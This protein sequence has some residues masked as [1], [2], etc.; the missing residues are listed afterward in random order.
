MKLVHILSNLLI[1]LVFLINNYLYIVSLDTSNVLFFYQILKNLK[2]DLEATTFN[3]S[4][5]FFPDKQIM[6]HSFFFQAPL[7]DHFFT[8]TIYLQPP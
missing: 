7:N 3:Q 4:A 1:I 5:S 8:I 2:L 6:I